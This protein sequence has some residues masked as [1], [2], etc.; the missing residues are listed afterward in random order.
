VFE[1][2]FEDNKQIVRR[3]LEGNQTTSDELLDSYDDAL[4]KKMRDM[5]NSCMDEGLLD[6]IG[7]S[8]LKQ[9]VHNIK[10]LFRNQVA[11]G[12]SNKHFNDKR[13]GLT[14]ALAYLHAR[15]ADF[16]INVTL[17]YLSGFQ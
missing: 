6:Q 14:A 5:Y 15:G 4:L 12:F 16:S 13:N 10:R 1:T 3:I 2:L 17:P 11:D 9:I 7:E 8:P